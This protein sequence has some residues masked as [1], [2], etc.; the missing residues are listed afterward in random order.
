MAS[1]F[2]YGFMS[3]NF[4]HF[5]CMC[6]S[7]HVFCLFVFFRAAAASRLKRIAFCGRRTESEIRYSVVSLY[8]FFFLFFYCNM[9]LFGWLVRVF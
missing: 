3:K 4:Y 6:V 2:E 7:V 1:C 8:S 9:F 5:L